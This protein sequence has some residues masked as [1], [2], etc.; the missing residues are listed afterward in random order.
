[1]ILTKKIFDV[2]KITGFVQLVEKRH[3]CSMQNLECNLNM[4]FHHK[5]HFQTKKPN[6]FDYDFFHHYSKTAETNQK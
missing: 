2:C 5:L 3:L 4:G 1:M 6:I